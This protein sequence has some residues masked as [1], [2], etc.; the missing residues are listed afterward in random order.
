MK[1]F[2]DQPKSLVTDALQGLAAS[3]SDLA[4]LDGFGKSINVVVDT[5]FN[6]DERVA[7]ISGG[8][9]GHE[10]AFAGYVGDGMLA[11]AVAGDIFASPSE[12]AVYAAIRHVTGSKGCLVIVMNYTGDRLH[13][14]AAVERAKAAGLRVRMLVVADD[15]ALPDAPPIGR[16]GIAGTLFALKIAGAAAVDGEDIDTVFK[17]AQQAIESVGSVGCS[18]SSC[19]IPGRESTER[20]G[21]EEMEIGLGIHGEPGAERVPLKPVGDIIRDLVRRITS[22]NKGSSGKRSGGID[23]KGGGKNQDVQASGAFEP[24]SSGPPLAFLKKGDRITLMMNN[25]GNM[26]RLETYSVAHAAVKEITENLL[27]DV[28][29]ARMHVGTFMTSLNMHGFSV[30]LLKVPSGDAGNIMLKRLDAP[31]L[32]LA[33]PSRSSVYSSDKRFLPLHEDLE[34]DSLFGDA[35]R[36]EDASTCAAPKEMD[37]CIASACEALLS[38]QEELD[39]LDAAVGDGDCG[40]TLAKGASAVLDLMKQTLFLESTSAAKKVLLLSRTI[41]ESMGGTSGAL[42]KLFLAAAGAELRRPSE[43]CPDGTVDA[44]LACAAFRAGIMAV[45]EYGGAHPGDRTMVDAFMPAVEALRESLESGKSAKEAALAMAE[46]AS[47]GA[48]STKYMHAGAGRSTYVPKET[49]KG[50]PD[51]GAVGAAMWL[52]AVAQSL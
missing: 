9:S 19:E 1:S 28:C 7:V 42:I 48:E 15:C 17:E 39:A 25:L 47:N 30:S 6:G 50:H 4:L 26:T 22:Y 49:L 14:G 11:A 51:P 23:E 43:E 37:R 40:S 36:E 10:P 18:L 29:L 45:I 33:W 32:A 5:N 27:P 2:V 21:A 35:A 34:S 52:H 8:G 20:M 46:A 31:T 44:N 38:A 41:G 3:S 13:F 16:R 24:S 12:D